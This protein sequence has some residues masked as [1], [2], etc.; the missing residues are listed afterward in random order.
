MS[1]HESSTTLGGN[2]AE[3]VEQRV[4]PIPGASR[5]GAAGRGRGWLVRRTLLVADL[6]G[7]V[8]AF[9][10]SELLFGYDG[11]PAD[12]VDQRLELLLFAA[13]LPGWIVVAKLYGLY[14]RDERRADC[15]TADD[16]SPVF[17]MVTVGA[18]LF[19]LGAWVTGLA[20]PDFAKL[21]TFWVLAI[22]LVALGRASARAFSRRRRAF[23]QNTIIVGAGDVGLLV[24]RKL[25][26]HGEY[27]LNLVGVWALAMLI[28]VLAPALGAQSNPVQALKVAA[29]GSTPY[30]LTGALAVLPKLGPIG[31]L[32]GFYSI[33]LFALGLALV[34][35]VP[36]D[37]A[38]AY[39][40]LASIGGIIVVLVI[41]A[42]SRVFV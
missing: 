3:A 19:F 14:D 8:L 30:W 42:L 41:G 27:G 16:I 32:L 33:R 20:E 34:L 29:Y 38:A 18:W 39:T 40:L 22:V 36:R 4:V 7:L 28:D 37:K 6:V 1:W 23:R 10:A 26:K 2:I 13:T 9:V 21:A 31:A 5:D 11:G 25:V 12:R 35:K 17:H 15:T 24:A